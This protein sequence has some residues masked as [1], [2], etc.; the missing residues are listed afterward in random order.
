RISA[1]AAVSKELKFDLEKIVLVRMIGTTGTADLQ[2]LFYLYDDINA[3]HKQLPPHLFSRLKPKD[4][5]SKE[6]E[7]T[8]DKPKDDA[9]SKEAETTA[10]NT[11]SL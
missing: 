4:A 5:K 3:A 6:A 9:K 7:T 10:E 11:K 1:V 8:A 2:G